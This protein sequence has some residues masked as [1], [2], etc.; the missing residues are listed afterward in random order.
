MN[1]EVIKE[2][3]VRREILENIFKL[4]DHNLLEDAA[5]SIGETLI[6]M[7]EDRD[8]HIKNILSKAKLDIDVDFEVELNITNS[9]ASSFACD[10]NYIELRISAPMDDLTIYCDEKTNKVLF[11]SI[12][13]YCKE[14]AL[15]CDDFADKYSEMAS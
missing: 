8:E 6:V 15:N 3:K 1:T 11:D 5:G 7:E 10:L 2:G 13:D 9:L 12:Y 4:G 14:I